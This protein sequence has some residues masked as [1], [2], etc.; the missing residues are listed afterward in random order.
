M[1]IQSSAYFLFFIYLS[2]SHHR[3]LLRA[4][5]V[6]RDDADG[7]QAGAELREVQLC[8][9]AFKFS[10]VDNL[11]KHVCN[12]DALHGFGLDCDV[13]IGRVREDGGTDGV[14]CNIG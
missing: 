13:A 14:F 1:T 6:G 10:I 5:T 3:N 9:V 7:E 12:D 11:A 4:N 2:L 8:F